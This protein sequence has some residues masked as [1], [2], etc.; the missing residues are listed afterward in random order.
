LLDTL[1]D[2]L[3]VARF[4]LNGFL[5]SNPNRKEYVKDDFKE[6]CYNN[7]DADKDEHDSPPRVDLVFG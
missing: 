3:I 1:F 4:V 5:S 6:D 2:G 7:P